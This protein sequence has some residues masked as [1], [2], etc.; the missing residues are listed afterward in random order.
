M[1]LIYIL[2]D[3]DYNLLLRAHHVACGL[4]LCGCHICKGKREKWSYQLVC[5]SLWPQR[6]PL[7][8]KRIAV[9]YFVIMGYCS[10]KGPGRFD[11]WNERLMFYTHAMS[12][13]ILSQMYPPPPRGEEWCGTRLRLSEFS[14]RNG[15][16]VPWSPAL[17]SFP[18]WRLIPCCIR[19]GVCQ[20]HRGT[21]LGKSLWR[22][23]QDN[24]PVGV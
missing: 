3:R 4:V 8:H 6:T 16:M 20:D 10:L 13:K 23:V 18:V 24:F 15:K 19:T 11:R 1:C 14:A 21:D 2:N 7:M 5:L 17:L 12:C 9:F 22:K